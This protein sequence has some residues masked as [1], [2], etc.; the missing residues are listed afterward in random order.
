M[1]VARRFFAPCEVAQLEQCAGETLDERFIELWTLKEAYV[2]ARGDG[3]SCPIDQFNFT[4]GDASTMAFATADPAVSAA[5][6]RFALL[7][8]SPRHRLALAVHQPHRAVQ[9]VVRRTLRLDDP[10]LTVTTPPLREL[11]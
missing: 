8:P 4:F 2:K 3:L 9:L 7:A 11:K 1:Q 10:P 5:A 6:W